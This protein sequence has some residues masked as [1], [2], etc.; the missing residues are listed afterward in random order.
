MLAIDIRHPW[1]FHIYETLSYLIQTSYIPLKLKT[2]CSHVERKKICRKKALWGLM[3]LTAIF[4]LSKFRTIPLSYNTGLIQIKMLTTFQCLSS[5][6]WSFLRHLIPKVKLVKKSLLFLRH[7]TFALHRPWVNS[8]SQWWN[9]CTKWDDC[10]S[11]S[12]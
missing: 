3:R 5:L 4:T 2:C 7:C 11:W 9:Y 8:I 12:L 10:T 6:I 1:L